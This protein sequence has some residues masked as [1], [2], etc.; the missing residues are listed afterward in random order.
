MPAA[1]QT[2]SSKTTHVYIATQ[3]ANERVSTGWLY[4]SKPASVVSLSRPGGFSFFSS[5]SSPPLSRLLPPWA[6]QLV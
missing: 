5:S 1:K 3:Y 4:V 2:C 6:H